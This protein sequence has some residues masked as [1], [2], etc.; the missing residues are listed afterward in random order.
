MLNPLSPPAVQGI[1]GIMPDFVD[2]AY[3]YPYTFSLEASETLTNQ[4][5]SV[6]TEADF[7]LRGIVF[8]SDDSFSFR[9]QDGLQYYVSPDFV[10][11]TA[12]PNSAAEPFPVVNEV[13]YPAG[14]RITIDIR[15]D[16]TDTNT[17]QILFLGVSRYRIRK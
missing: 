6:L 3:G 11:D 10:A 7:L 12:M 2:R 9:Y 5:V 1:S 16:I 8:V 17:G 14:G 13:F 4:V 15:N